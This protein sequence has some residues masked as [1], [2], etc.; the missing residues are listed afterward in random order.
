MVNSISHKAVSILLRIALFW[1]TAAGASD[2]MF[3][4]ITL[5]CDADADVLTIT[6]TLLESGSDAAFD[7][8]AEDGRYSPWDM[9]EVAR[10]TDSTRIIKSTKTT[11]NCWLSSGEYTIVLEPQIF[12]HDLGSRCGENISGAVTV[13]H[14]G[15]EILGRTAFEEHCDGN[16]PVITR[17]TV[18]GKTA[19]Y[20]IKRIPRH[21][22]Y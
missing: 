15:T 22:F 1:M 3:P 19:A 10:E 8:S 11:T 5:K 6:N 2:T 7:Y 20:K 18:F 4:L 9:V 14:Q 12:S 21:R 17:I 13:R 16:I